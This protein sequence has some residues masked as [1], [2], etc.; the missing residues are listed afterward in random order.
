MDDTQFLRDITSFIK[1]SAERIH[2]LETELEQE[3]AR[4]SKSSGAV[5]ETERLK[6]V[7]V[8]SL[9]ESATRKLVTTMEKIGMVDAKHVD[10]TVK[11]YRE[12]P[13]KLLKFC[14]ESLDPLVDTVASHP[15]TPVEG[16]EKETPKQE[17]N[18]FDVQVENV[19]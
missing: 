5:E 11:A 19:G 18:F 7:K 4:H 8:A 1:S 6:L 10:G 14:Q 9:D 2:A 17:D 3:K 15:G 13:N 16:S 12:D